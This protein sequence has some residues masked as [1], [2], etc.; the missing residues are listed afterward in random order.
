MRAMS[1]SKSE[2][3][4]LKEAKRVGRGIST[5][6]ME[7]RDCEGGCGGVMGGSEGAIR[8]EMDWDEGAGRLVWGGMEGG[9]SER[10]GRT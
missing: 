2:P 1:A 4:Y 7:S 9:K 6:N 8:V 3:V 5:K 10:K